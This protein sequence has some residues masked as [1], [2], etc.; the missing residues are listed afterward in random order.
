MAKS[1][2]AVAKALTIPAP[3]LG[4]VVDTSGMAKSIQAVAKALTVSGPS[5]G[6]VVDTLGMVKSIQAVAKALA[7][8]I[9]SSSTGSS[10]SSGSSSIPTS[11]GML[12]YDI[13]TDGFI[14]TDK[15]GDKPLKY[16]HLI[17][18]IKVSTTV[19]AGTITDVYKNKGDIIRPGDPIMKIETTLIE[20][21][22]GESGVIEYIAEKDAIITATDTVYSYTPADNIEVSNYKFDGTKYEPDI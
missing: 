20:A 5:P 12:K 4:P 9:S 7:T 13:P 22:A 6:P 17:E 14:I 1:I 18:P 21:K 16:V 3:P 10:G 8:A 15:E 11:T 2:Q 19:P